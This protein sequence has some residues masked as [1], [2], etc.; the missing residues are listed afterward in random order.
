MPHETF[1]VLGPRYGESLHV[2]MERMRKDISE[3][4]DIISSLGGEVVGQVVTNEGIAD[5]L[6]IT[7]DFR[8]S[9]AELASGRAEESSKAVKA[10][11]VGYDAD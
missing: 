8:E 11:L 9:Q 10:K 7:A 6:F 2:A 5:L 1:V 4:H 3:Q